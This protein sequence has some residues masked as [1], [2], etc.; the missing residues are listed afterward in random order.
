MVLSECLFVFQAF[1]LFERRNAHLYSS[2]VEVCSAGLCGP[3]NRP[4]CRPFWLSR[5]GKR[6]RTR[7]KYHLKARK[8]YKTV[9][10]LFF[11]K[12]SFFQCAKCEKVRKFA[13]SW[14]LLHAL[15]TFLRTFCTQF[16]HLRDSYF[17]R[18]KQA[19]KKM[20]YFGRYGPYNGAQKHEISSF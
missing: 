15:R 5:P 11:E 2:C 12:N 14:S 1:F 13:Q 10:K 18:K 19:W 4:H 20:K 8:V 9:L 17:T 16:F 7:T 6:F 3:K